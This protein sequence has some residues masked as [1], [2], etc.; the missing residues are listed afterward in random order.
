MRCEAQIARAQSFPDAHARI[1][2][3]ARKHWVENGVLLAY[4][5]RTFQTWQPKLPAF[6]N[7]YLE[8]LYSHRETYVNIEITMATEFWWQYF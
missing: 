5:F 4:I 3:P 1:P 6:A 8:I 2:K 7:M